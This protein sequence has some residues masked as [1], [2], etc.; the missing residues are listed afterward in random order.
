MPRL[1]RPSCVFSFLGC[2]LLW[3]ARKT[4]V[5]LDLVVL[6]VCEF[7]IHPVKFVCCD[8]HRHF[9]HDMLT[10]FVF[11]SLDLPPFS[12]FALIVLS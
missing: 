8:R 11:S 2:F 9:L 7:V 6:P 3:P 10:L 5:P 1:A 4:T 12:C